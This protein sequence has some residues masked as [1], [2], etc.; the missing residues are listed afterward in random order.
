MLGPTLLDMQEQRRAIVAWSGAVAAVCLG[1][2]AVL[3]HNWFVLAL[4]IAVVAFVILLVAGIPDLAGWVRERLERRSDQRKRRP[5]AAVTDRWHATS[6]GFKAAALSR[7]GSVGLSHPGYMRPTDDKRPSVRFGTLIACDT[8]GPTPELTELRSRF[9]AFL[10]TQP[11]MDL[12]STLSA[13]GS[14]ESWRSLA[15]HGRWMLEAAMMAED[16]THAPVAS[17]MLLLPEAGM[18]ARFGTEASSAEL[19]LHIEP[20]TKEGKPAP[21]VG[22]A[23]WQ[24][25]FVQALGLSATLAGF[26]TDNLGLVTSDDPSAKFALIMDTLGPLTELVDIGD[27]KPLPG[28]QV[29]NQFTGWAVAEPAGK[30]PS[31]TARDLMANLCE[32]ALGGLD[33]Y[34]SALPPVGLSRHPHM[35]RTACQVRQKYGP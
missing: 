7:M 28:G 26:L 13:V 35:P 20:R 11:I 27:L 4:V 21:P 22:L 34:E 33:G 15:G 29:L 1:L 31:G 2:A 14:D 23:E 3:P 19:I 6:N 12:V 17:A 5:R 32:G 9:R 25:R 24:D 10:A 30:S 18:P 8:L 16:Q